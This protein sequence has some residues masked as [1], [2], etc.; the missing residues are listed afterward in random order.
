MF[1]GGGGVRGAGA[2]GPGQKAEKGF[3][4]NGGW[5][6]DPVLREVGHDQRRGNCGPVA[7]DHHANRID[8]RVLQIRT[9]E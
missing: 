8:S 2:P 6:E 7:A 4:G 3:I 9:H 1:W 5:T